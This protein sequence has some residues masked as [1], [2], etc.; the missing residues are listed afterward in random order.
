MIF[1]KKTMPK[2]NIP[3]VVLAAGESARL[4]QPK[5]NVVYQ[6]KTLLEH[7]IHTASLVSENIYVVLGA[8]LDTIIKTNWPKNIHILTNNSWATG[9]ASSIRLA[10]E[11]LQAAEAIVF[12]VCD[13]VFVNEDILRKLLNTYL[14]STKKIIACLYTHGQ[15]VPMLVARQ[16]F[17]ELLAL[18]G[19][20]G[21]RI[22]LNKYPSEVAWVPFSEGHIDIDNPA[23]LALLHKKSQN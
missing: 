17:D 19:Q 21:A 11:H 16:L 12:M 7:S 4:G 2:S 10:T 22:L 8:H 18:E 9:M 1:Y 5:Q 3:I 23:D 13:Q 14:Q 6:N 15:G 20:K